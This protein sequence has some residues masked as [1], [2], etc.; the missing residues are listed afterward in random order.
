MA[1]LTV[2]LAP[3]EWFLSARS[4]GRDAMHGPRDQRKERTMKKRLLGAALAGGLVLALAPAASAYDVNLTF[5]QKSATAR[6][7]KGAVAGDIVGALRTSL[8]SRRVDGEKWRVSTEW[9]VTAGSQSFAAR[10]R[11]V[12]NVRTRA[13]LLRGRIVSG[14]LEGVQAYAKGRLVNRKTGRLVG[15]L[16]LVPVHASTPALP[17]PAPTLTPAPAPTDDFP[18]HPASPDGGADPRFAE[19]C[20]V[21]VP[22]V[23]EAPS[24]GG[25]NTPAVVL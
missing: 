8:R 11:G 9:I 1:A 10:L 15:R 5:D 12:I 23:V 18:C 6:V 19:G 24:E 21:S 16:K 22:P 25:D 13:V 4:Y 17:S 20:G 3:F 14:H 2:V 7:W